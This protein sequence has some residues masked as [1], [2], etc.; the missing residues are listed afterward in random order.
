MHRCVESKK[1]QK[2]TPFKQQQNKGGMSILTS[3][4]V[5][6]KARNSIQI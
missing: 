4:K 2:D 5:D 3:Y 6:F 1:I